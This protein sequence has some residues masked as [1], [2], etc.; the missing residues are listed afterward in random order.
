L[1]FGPALFQRGILMRKSIALTIT[2]VVLSLCVYLKA[3]SGAATTDCKV[4]LRL[5]DS[6]TGQSLGGMVRIFRTGQAEPV[7]LAGLIDR[8]RGLE[9]SATVAGWYVVPASGAETSLPRAKLR[10]EAVAGLE[11]ALSRQEIDL[12]RGNAEEVTVPLRLLFRPD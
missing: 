2:G 3:D 7:L 4:R 5:V 9:R 6:Q 10:L 8:L 1:S 11:S 12:T